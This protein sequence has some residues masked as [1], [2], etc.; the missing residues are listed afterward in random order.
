MSKTNV[1]ITG[2]SQQFVDEICKRLA[3]E[4]DMFYAN[5]QELFEYELVD[6]E[7]MEAVCGLEYLLKEEQS[8]IRRVCGYENTLINIDFPIINNES[9]LEIVKSNCLLI[10]L[11]ID[12]DLFK[13]RQIIDGISIN[14]REI[15][16]DLFILR[17]NVCKENADIVIECNENTINDLISKI[18][19]QIIKYFT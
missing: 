13:N 11:R 7:K 15:N 4:L 3:I 5:I 2:L 16:N 8:I 12:K 6:C 18:I 9:T 10:Y 19:D 17:D 14:L 1:C